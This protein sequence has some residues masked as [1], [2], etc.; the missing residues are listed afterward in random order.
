MAFPS[1]S[2]TARSPTTFFRKLWASIIKYASFVGPGAMV[3][4][5][6]M[7]P[8]NYATDVTAG[9]SYRFQLLFVV[10]ISN[11]IAI[12]LQSLSI[13]LGSVTGLNLAQMIK[14]HTHP[15]LNA[16]LYVVAEI[17]IIA[18][19]MAEVIGTAIALDLLFKIPLVAGCIIS[20]A[21]VLLI[22]LF[23]S[24]GNSIRA[25]RIFE[26][27]VF[28]L[29]LAVV[30]CF[31]Y[32]L[33]LIQN[34]D[35]GTVLRGYVPNSAILQ[36]QGMYQACGIL[37]ATVM[38]HSLYLGSGTIQSRL[39]KYD[40][41]HGLAPKSTVISFETATKAPRPSDESTTTSDSNASLP[42]PSLYLPSL[43]AIRHGLKMS[44][45]ELTIS[46]FTFALFVNSAILIIAGASLYSDSDA[47]SADLFGIHDL[48]SKHLAPAAGTLF[49]TALLLSGISAGIVCTIAG[50]IISEGQVSWHIKP[51]QRRILTRSIAITPSVIIAGSIGKEGISKAL[52]ASQ[53]VLCFCLPIITA[54]LLWFTSK[55]K[56]QRVQVMPNGERITAG[57]D[58]ELEDEVEEEDRLGREGEEIVSSHA[59]S[60]STSTAL[61]NGGTAER[62]MSTLVSA[63]EAPSAQ[64]ASRTEGAG[65]VVGTGLL[66]GTIQTVQFHN[67]WATTA[68][69]L[70]IWLVILAMNM[71][72]VVMLALGVGD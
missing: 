58:L 53:V 68:I 66:P 6:Y 62:R 39:L 47:A 23:Y 55:A 51:W 46:L 12:V 5:A 54:P 38:P 7:D 21:D 37:G 25:V 14:A 1:S 72:A 35:V 69:S 2:S 33:S 29:V 44:I 61:S 40:Q 64:A 65:G 10:L 52:E 24:P 31:C 17:A 32:Q 50:Q 15:Y 45:I 67:H 41:T 70:L 26:L 59:R 22:L 4:V 48:L 19:D 49:A 16:F 3:S 56:Y 8:G 30:V 57:D 43:R 28:A 34:T 42:S 60:P 63:E 20:I 36:K 11:I 13:K 71:A 18:T 9:A 27:G